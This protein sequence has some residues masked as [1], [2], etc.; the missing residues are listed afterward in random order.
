MLV[1]EVFL[2]IRLRCVCAFGLC[3]FEDGVIA[4]R[5]KRELDGHRLDHHVFLPLL[6]ATSWDLLPDRESLTLLKVLGNF[7]NACFCPIEANTDVFR[8]HHT[9]PWNLG[10]WHASRGSE[11]E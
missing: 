10:D 6:Y 9:C 4:K 5:H 8:S 1:P 2:T 11:I 7:L 3:V